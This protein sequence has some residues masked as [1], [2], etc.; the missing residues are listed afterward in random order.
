VKQQADTQPLYRCH[1]EQ[2]RAHFESNRSDCEGQGKNERLLG[3][4]LVR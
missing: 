4:D 3:Y 1:A 2:D